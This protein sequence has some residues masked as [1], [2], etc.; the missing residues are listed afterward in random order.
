MKVC[1]KI[2]SV[3]G[4]TLV[5]TMIATLIFTMI[6]GALYV[7][8]NAGQASWETNKTKIELQQEARKAMDWMIND[9]RQSGNSSIVDVPAT[10]AWFNQITFKTPSGVT[11]GSISWNLAT[12]RFAKSGT[13]L[14]RTDTNGTKVIAQD[15]QTIQFRRLS[16]AANILEV[17]I[18]T[19]KTTAKGLVV[20][21]P[22]NFSI[23]IRNS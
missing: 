15:I 12:I 20:Q 2:Y 22:F 4:V 1:K 5:E 3:C 7:V 9:L 23:Q 18:T 14:Q 21:Y 16:T 6:V 17:A 13:Q 19:Q 10:G 11:S 8:L